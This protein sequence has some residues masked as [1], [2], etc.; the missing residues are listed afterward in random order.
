M[1]IE[2]M[3]GLLLLHFCGAILDEPVC[4]AD[5]DVADCVFRLN[6]LYFIIRCAFLR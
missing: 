2:G 1:I 4:V 6:A 5:I 3:D